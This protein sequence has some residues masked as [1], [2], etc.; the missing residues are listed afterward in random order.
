MSGCRTPAGE[1][2]GPR[3]YGYAPDRITVIGAEAD[4]IREC[5]R[6]VLAGESQSS[7]CNDL[8]GRA[9]TTAAKPWRTSAL[10]DTLIAA[11]ISGR[12]EYHGDIT[13]GQAWPRIITQ[14][15]PTSSA[16][17]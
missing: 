17:C 13:A 4:V 8:N 9:I 6:R 5:A 2:G 11:R 14:T 7:V 12:R 16:P 10:K 15:S 3:A 1:Q